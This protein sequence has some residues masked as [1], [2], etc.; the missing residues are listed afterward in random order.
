MTDETSLDP[1][2]W[3][4]LRGLGHRMLDDMFDYLQTVRERP[5]WRPFPAAA[6]ARLEEPVPFEETPAEDVYETFRRDILPYPT[7]NIHPRYWGWVKGT[8]T[9]L[10]M[11][12][13]MLAAGMNA[14]LAGFD[15]SAVVVEKR[16]IAWLVELLSFPRETS[17]LLVSGGSMA[18]FVGL[19]AARQAR[20]GFDVRT[21]GLQGSHPLLTVY[22]ST[23][24]HNSIQKAIELL[25][26]GAKALRQIPVDSDYRIDIDALRRAVAADRL[27]G[28]RPIAVVG[29]AGTVNTGAI[30][31]LEA[32]ATLARAEGLWL[33]VDG[34]FGALAALAP[35]LRPLV[36][37]LNR[38]D[39][40]AFDLHKWGYLPFEIG[41]V[42]VRDPV[43]HRAGFALSASYLSTLDRGPAAAG[44]PFA[45]L[46]VQ[47]TRGF[48]ALK[49]WMALKTHGVRRIAEQIQQNVDQARYLRDLVLGHSQ[50]ALMAPVPLNVVCLRFI[51]PGLGDDRT[52]AIN[53]EILLR[54]Q[55]QGLAM[56]SHTVLNGR[57]ALRCAIVNH[58]TRR[59]DL[60][61][62][63][64]AVVNT[65][66][67]LLASQ[68]GADLAP[69]TAGVRSTLES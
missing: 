38:A 63:V 15:Q 37:G 24:T 68:W 34:A 62:F 31:N 7:G 53:R 28:H 61:L 40:V 56:P 58:R 14:H 49:V 36:V 44:L 22:C 29:N 35:D 17:G 50:L 45:E 26:L 69:V 39:S 55:E 6:R 41:C 32:L 59:D 65:G 57:F 11:L 30:D 1:A 8:G 18:N 12:S 54:I 4:D 9:P 46:G 42:L 16:V 25:G 19:A 64:Q 23:E 2:N 47:L 67:A 33:H 21:E 27:A 52:D 5:V 20:A 43:A 13:E 48:R 3:D 60:D 10:G 66:N 51:A